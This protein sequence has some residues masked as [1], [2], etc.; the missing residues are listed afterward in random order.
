MF[1]YRKIN[2][3]VMHDTKKHY[4][5]NPILREA[6]IKSI[7]QQYMVA[8][9]E[10]ISVDAATACHTKYVVS[11]KRSFEAAKAYKGKKVAVLNFANNHSIG[12]SPFS[13]GAQEESLCRC[14]TLLPCLEAMK[15]MFYDTH[16]RQYENGEIDFRGNDDLI[17]TPNVVVFKSDES[18]EPI[19]PKMIDDWYEVN[20]ITSAAPEIGDRSLPSNYEQLITSRIKK[21]LDVAAR[22]K[23]EVLILGAWGCGAFKNPTDIVARV[24]F[25]L[26]KNYDFETVEFALSSKGNI[27]NSPFAKYCGCKE[28]PDIKDTIVSLLEST[29]RENISIVIHFLTNHGFFDVPAS[30]QHHNNFA[31]GLA[32]H[33][34]EV[35]REAMRLNEEMKLPV[36]SVTLCSL[37]HD[38]CKYDQFAMLDGHPISIT[39]CL[40]KGHGRRSMYIL[41]RKCGLPLNYDEAMAIWWHMGEHEPSKEWCQNE[42]DEACN[43]PLCKLIQQAD[44]IAAHKEE[45]TH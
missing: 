26:L 2:F 4:E 32:K 9:E 27:S 37:L 19:Y 42:Y 30:V 17:Y 22:E 43:I 3:E 36:T 34:L 41:T 5:S 10:D 15:Y 28:E 21:I 7:R 29:G 33:S 16:I 35:Y 39:A 23:N 13:A 45:N 38:V 14:S 12:G 31:G 8:A 11:G 1:N 20:I 18:T 24:F 25:S 40:Q 6:V 44:S